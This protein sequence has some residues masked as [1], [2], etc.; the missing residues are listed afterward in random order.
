MCISCGCGRYE[1]S[2]GDE[3]NITVD[4]LQ[5]AADA[6]NKTL[7]EVVGAMAK[8]CADMQSSGIPHHDTAGQAVK[9]RLHEK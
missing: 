1:L 7:A 9:E 8:G 3:R 4:T 2:H 5:R 6:S